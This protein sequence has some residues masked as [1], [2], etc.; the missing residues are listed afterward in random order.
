MSFILVLGYSYEITSIG[1]LFWGS[2]FNLIISIVKI[3]GYYYFFKTIIY[4]FIKFSQKEF[5]CKNRIINKYITRM[6]DY[7]KE[8]GRESGYNI[9]HILKCKSILF[10]YLKK[11]TFFFTSLS[12]LSLYTKNIFYAIY[13]HKNLKIC[14]F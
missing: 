6:K 5:G 7:I 12:V 3:L 4:Y 10:S 1:N 9:F 11:L 2:I 13:F 8:C 14:A